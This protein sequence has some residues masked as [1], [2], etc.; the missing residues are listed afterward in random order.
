MD[1]PRSK[2][3]KVATVDEISEA[4]EKL[5]PEEWAKLYAYAKNRAR[6]MALYGAAL[7]AED[8]VQSAIT[9][10]LEER[11]TWNPKKVTFIGVLMGAMKSIASNHKEKSLKSGYSVPESQLAAGDEDDESETPVELH[12][13]SLPNPEKQLLAAEHEKESIGFVED[14]YAFFGDDLEALLVMDCWKEGLTGTEIIQTLEIDRKAYETIVRRIR[15]KSTAQWPK[16][17][18]HV[19]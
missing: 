18:S 12:P 19:S 4:I 5:L 2:S 8:L 3:E 7:D 1:K 10:M 17:S 13:D 16:G 9:A 11:R 14:L 15:R 6:M